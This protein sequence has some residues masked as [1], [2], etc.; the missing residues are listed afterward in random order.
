MWANKYFL[1]SWEES[2]GQTRN[3][4]E[5]C[6]ISPGLG[7][8]LEPQQQLESV[9]GERDVC[10]I[11]LTPKFHQIRV[12]SVSYLP[13]QWGYALA[14]VCTSTGSAALRIYSA[15]A[16]AVRTL[17]R[18]IYQPSRVAVCHAALKCSRSTAPLEKRTTRD[19][20]QYW[21]WVYL[22]LCLLF[23]KKAHTLPII[24]RF[25]NKYIISIHQI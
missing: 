9:A 22:I 20:N 25:A 13:Q 23:W 1:T 7:M 12:E 4:L 11:L 2:L 19:C 5:G 16:L 8:S 6:Y 3:L 14:S 15:A 10:N 24:C 18:Q 17:Q 21:S